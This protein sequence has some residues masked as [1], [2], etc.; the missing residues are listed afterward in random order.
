MRRLLPLLLLLG[1]VCPV[2]S[3]EAW[4]PVVG[5]PYPD[6]KLVNQD[7]K[8]T[9]LSSFRGKLI[10]VEPIGMT[11]PACNAFSDCDQVGGFAGQAQQKDLPS[12]RQAAQ[13]YGRVRLP[14]QQVVLVQLLLYDRAMKPPS[15]KDAK[16]WAAHFNLR[17][18]NNEYVLVG[19]KQH[20]VYELVPGFQL[21]DR[22]FT[23][24]SDSTGHSPQ[25]DLYRHLFPMLG[26]LVNS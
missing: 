23:L 19:K 25:H 20:Q 10:V 3:K 6:L 18:S 15:L 22:N 4:P 7:G 2:G 9:Q 13:D 17:T 8:Q 5:M 16:A 26:R 14:S 12:F 11:C 1:L 21:I 24:V